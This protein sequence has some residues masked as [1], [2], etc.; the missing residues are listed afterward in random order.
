MMG[1]LSLIMQLV[2]PGIPLGVAGGK[3]EFAQVPAILGA[4]FSGAIGG[5]ICGF[6]HGV[7]SPAFLAL[8]PSTMLNL[9]LLGYIA[10]NLKIKGRIIIAIIISRIILGPV[11]AAI[12]FKLLYYTGATYLSIWILGLTFG[13]PSAIVSIPLSTLLQKRNREI[14]YTLTK[15]LS[16]TI[17]FKKKRD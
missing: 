6:L 2:V 12:I 15:K 13:I 14:L 10:D 17:F 7:Y 16:K 5:I 8:I 11:F 3:L 9:G 1:T 4:C